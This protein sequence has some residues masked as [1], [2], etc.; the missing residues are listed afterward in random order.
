VFFGVGPVVCAVFLAAS[1]RFGVGRGVGFVGVWLCGRGLW[2][3]S[4]WVAVVESSWSVNV[5]VLCV[6]VAEPG[7]G[8]GFACRDRGDRVG[9]C[10]GGEMGYGGGGGQARTGVGGSEVFVAS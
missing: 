7:W 3:W 10:W 6:G 8:R 4:W 5:V 2:F 1:L 9:G